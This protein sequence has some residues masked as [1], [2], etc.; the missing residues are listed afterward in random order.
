MAPAAT[1]E[2]QHTRA[3]ALAVKGFSRNLPFF[4]PLHSCTFPFSGSFRSTVVKID[5]ITHI[6]VCMYIVGR[7]IC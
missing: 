4:R 7:V 2:W 3:R 6:F 5:L 1:G